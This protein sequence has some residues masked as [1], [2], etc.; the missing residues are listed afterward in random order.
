M[1]N[2]YKSDMGHRAAGNTPLLVGPD[3]V[4]KIMGES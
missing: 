1:D 2:A 3:K 4:E